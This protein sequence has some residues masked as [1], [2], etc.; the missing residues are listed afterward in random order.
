MD[1]WQRALLET[2]QDTS[3]PNKEKK[4]PSTYRY[5]LDHWNHDH[6]LS[7]RETQCIYL[8]MLGKETAKELDLSPR[9]VEFY[10]KRIKE[11]FNIKKKKDLILSLEESGMN[12][13]TISKD[14]LE[15]RSS[16][17]D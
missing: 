4:P 12:L 7:K 6:Y 13:K 14:E 16:C 9:T 3:L 5:R 10:F 15:I 2:Q 11:R 1:F 17:Y 8:S